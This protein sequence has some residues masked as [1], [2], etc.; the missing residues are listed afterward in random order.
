MTKKKNEVEI[1]EDPQTKFIQKQHIDPL[2]KRVDILEKKTL[3]EVHRDFFNRL[4]SEATG[5]GKFNE[6]IE[7]LFGKFLKTEGFIN[8]VNH[9]AGKE[10]R[11]YVDK[12]RIKIIFWIIGLIVVTFVGM[13][14]QKFGNI[15]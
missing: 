4:F 15:F 2:S 11:T 8:K 5:A 7:R 14:I 3:D 10:A 1:F 9:L 12:S 6:K 13:I